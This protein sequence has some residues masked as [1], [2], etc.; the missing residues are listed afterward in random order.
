MTC[1]SLLNCRAAKTKKWLFWPQGGSSLFQKSPQPLR[2]PHIM[3]P[4]HCQDIHRPP[5]AGSLPPN[6]HREWRC[7]I[8][9]ACFLQEEMIQRENRRR[10]ELLWIEVFQFKIIWRFYWLV[11][12]CH[13]NEA[14][15]P[16]QKVNQSQVT[17]AQ[18]QHCGSP[19]PSSEWV[20]LQEEA[21]VPLRE[22]FWGRY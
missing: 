17:L 7:K 14:K 18:T 8:L 19:E 2:S 11:Y 10:K 13:P 12:Q 6:Q 20:G 21:C 4:S 1:P 9:N 5:R 3:L 22:R 16:T 15:C